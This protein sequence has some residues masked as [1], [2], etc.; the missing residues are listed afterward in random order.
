MLFDTVRAWIQQFPEL[1]NCQAY[2]T[3]QEVNHLGR[4]LIVVDACLKLVVF[5]LPFLSYIIHLRSAFC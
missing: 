1:E 5:L 3:T 2:F 4:A